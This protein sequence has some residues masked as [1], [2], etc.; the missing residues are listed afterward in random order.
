MNTNEKIKAGI[1]VDPQDL[2]D[3]VSHLE[4]FEFDSV[5]VEN[6]SMQPFV[7]FVGHEDDITEWTG[8]FNRFGISEDDVVIMNWS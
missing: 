6:S 8:E 4:D 7:S 1:F 2:N 5:T 3:I